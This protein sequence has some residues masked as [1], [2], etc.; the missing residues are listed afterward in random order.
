MLDLKPYHDAVITADAE[1]QRIANE[2]DAAFLKGT[3][4]GTG[5][6]LALR[7]ALDEAQAKYDSAIKLYESLKK[8]SQPSNVATNFVPVSPTLPDPEGEKPKGI[9]KLSE[10]QN[11]VPSERMK[12]IKGGGKVED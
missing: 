7:P 10:F 11:L 12:F 8:A 2:I 9:M 4:E 5:Q 6:A 3:E 1:V